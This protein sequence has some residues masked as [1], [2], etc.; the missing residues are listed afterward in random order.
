MWQQACNALVKCAQCY[1]MQQSTLQQASTYRDAANCCRHISMEV[2][3][4]L[5][6]S[7]IDLYKLMGKSLQVAQINNEISKWKEQ[8]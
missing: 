6:K 7:A 1:S 8:R 2:A 5:W 4:P 3:T